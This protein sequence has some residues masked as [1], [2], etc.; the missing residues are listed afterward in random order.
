MKMKNSF[1]LILLS[2][3]YLC[4]AQNVKIE[5]A[6]T[7]TSIY[8]SNYEEV[9]SRTDTLL[10]KT[11]LLSNKKENMLLSATETDGRYMILLDMSIKVM[12]L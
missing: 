4:Q 9:S 3:V 5:Y 6:K 11:I 10:R 2:F 8:N 7:A 1:F 12:I